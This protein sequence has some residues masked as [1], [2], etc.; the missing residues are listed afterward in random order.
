MTQHKYLVNVEYNEKKSEIICY[1]K[2]DY[3]QIAKRFSFKPYLVLN[4]LF[5][6]KILELL[7]FFKIK[8][9]FVKEHNNKICVFSNSFEVLKKISNLLAIITNK[10]HLVLEPERIFLIEKDWS[11]FDSFSFENNYPKKIF[12]KK[13]FS[14]ALIP[15][16][17]FK[18]ALNID[19]NQTLFLI[20]QSA[21]SNILKI[22]L[23]KIPFSIEEKTEIFLENIYF[24]HGGTINWDNE[25][26]FYSKKEFA[27][28]GFFENFSEIDFSHVWLQSLTNI[29]FNIGQ[30][31]INCDCCKPI[32]IDDFNLLPST[33]I[34]VVSR[35]KDLFYISSSNTFSNSFNYKNSEKEIR[36]NKKNEFFLKNFPIG[37]LKYD[38]KYL[39]PLED[40]I[41]LLNEKKVFLSKNHS[42]FW[43]CKKKESFLSKEIKKI[44]KEIFCVKENLDFYSKNLLLENSFDFFFSSKILFSLKKISLE[45]P[46]HLTN[47]FSKFFSLTIAKSIDSVQENILYKFKEFS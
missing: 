29:F 7:F 44:N 47:P 43:F 20:E 37:P 3:S 5:N 18:E 40:A 22:P 33:L 35:K 34:E 14:F 10:K 12:S 6:K 17:I 30:D 8:N 24:K 39:L 32:K 31:T 46:F 21:F 15:K 36:K 26:K 4:S 25:K 23:N 38:K 27:P 9:F 41:K 45:I 19:R 11:Y 13:D 16:I 1:F 28:Y 2:N 42:L